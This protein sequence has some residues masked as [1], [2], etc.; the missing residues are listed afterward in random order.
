MKRIDPRYQSLYD[1]D[2]QQDDDQITAFFKI[3]KDFDIDIISINCDITESEKSSL[4]V[5]IPNEPPIICGSLFAEVI[6][7]SVK[8][9]VESKNANGKHDTYFNITL[10]K[11]SKFIWPAL[12]VGRH[13]KTND[14][15]PK[16]VYLMY[17]IKAESPKKE[18]KRL[19]LDEISYAVDLGLPVAIRVYSG[20][21]FE[22][23]EREKGI[24]MLKFAADEYNDP[25]AMC[26]LGRIFFYWKKETKKEGLEYLK[27]ASKLGKSEVNGFIG[28]I[29]SPFSK[30]EYDEKDPEE[31]VHYLQLAVASKKESE[32]SSGTEIV[33]EEEEEDTGNEDG[34]EKINDIDD[35]DEINEY[36]QELNK[37][38]ASGIIKSKKSKTATIFAV[39]TA[40]ILL[41]VGVALVLHFRRRR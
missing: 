3:P 25:D 23:D 10:Q 38:L 17:I 31:A 11:K 15:D 14:I 21:L 8:T 22:K 7:E 20:I 40:A 1:Y 39:S 19:A 6:P 16:S 32:S 18:D 5:T 9:L 34:K 28:Q 36:E 33:I 4:S 41:T 12:I 26:Q 30:F 13:P 35:K 29:L 37:I 27:K 24:E 2:V